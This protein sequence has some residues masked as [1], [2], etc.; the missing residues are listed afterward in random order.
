MQSKV[1]IE[2]S[3]VFRMGELHIVF[4]MLKSIGKYIDSSGLDQLFVEADIYGLAVLDQIKGGKHMKRSFEAY[5]ALYNALFQI[6]SEQMIE[7]NPL[8]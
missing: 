4:A 1:E 8:L 2:E 7:E 3:Y 5:M 6:Y